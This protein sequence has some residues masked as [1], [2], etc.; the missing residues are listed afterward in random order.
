MGGWTSAFKGLGNT[1]RDEFFEGMFKGHK[2]MPSVGG[3]VKKAWSGADNK[4][5][6]MMAGAGA[7]AISPAISVAENVGQGFRDNPI[8][9]SLLVGGVGAGLAFGASSALKA[10]TKAAIKNRGGKDAIR[11]LSADAKLVGENV[12]KNADEFFEAEYKQS[13]KALGKEFGKD[14]DKYKT[15]MGLASKSTDA[16]Y[17]SAMRK[18]ATRQVDNFAGAG[19]S[20]KVGT[21]NYR[22]VM[23][24]D[25]SGGSMMQAGLATAGAGMMYGVAGKA[26]ND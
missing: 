7:L 24:K 25:V 11:A 13:S 15:A 19:G 22:E 18:G 8:A 3:A 10:G 21:K 26:W 17:E 5:K 2:L 1:A 23:N 6:M 4:G 12:Y 20:K 9:T 14:T 16:K